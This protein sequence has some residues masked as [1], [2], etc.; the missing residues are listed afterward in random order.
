MV[1]IVHG[2][3]SH[4]QMVIFLALPQTYDVATGISPMY[5]ATL[6]FGDGIHVFSKRGPLG[7]TLHEVGLNQDGLKPSSSDRSQFH[8][9]WLSNVT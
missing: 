5:V 8:T 4:N 9:L 6:D 7:P 1:G 2:Y 3:V